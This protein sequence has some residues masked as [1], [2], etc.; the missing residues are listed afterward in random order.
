MLAYLYCY[1]E[2]MIPSPVQVKTSDD[3]LGDVPSDTIS[4]AKYLIGCGSPPQCL[5]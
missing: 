1:C 3:T 2:M 5:I 4:D